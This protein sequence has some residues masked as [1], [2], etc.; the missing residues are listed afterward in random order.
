MLGLNKMCEAEKDK[1]CQNIYD[2]YILGTS[3]FLE[4]CDEAAKVLRTYI[5]SGCYTNFRDTLFHFRCMVDANDEGIILNQAAS[6]MEHANRAMR[7]AEAAL[8]VRCVTI[9]DMLKQRYHFEA[10][11]LKL[12][13]QQ[14]NVLKDCIMKLRLG[15]MMLEGME[16]LYPSN[17]KFL[18]IM[19]EYFT[20][21]ATYAGDE[22][23]EVIAY[24]QK[25]KDEFKEVV[26]KAFAS[27]ESELYNFKA[28]ATYNDVAELVYEA[29]FDN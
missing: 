18:D 14:I 20:C 15:S 17:E 1:Y 16:F 3:D 6:I 21:A 5:P 19:Q 28:F 4:S 23:K 24:S 29:V 9:F 7:D 10:D 26:K 13:D 22:F 25:L 2:E 12:I 27:R 11:I 8:C